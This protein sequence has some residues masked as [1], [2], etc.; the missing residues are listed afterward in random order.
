MVHSGCDTNV[1]A[2]SLAAHF[3]IT[4]TYSK[5]ADSFWWPNMKLDV[6]NF[7]KCCDICQRSNTRFDKTNN[8]LHSIP[9]PT[10]VWT[11][12]GVDLTALPESEDG[13]K[14]IAVAVDYFSKYIVAMPLKDKTAK[15]ISRFLYSLLCTHGRAKIQINDQ[16]REFVNEIS[17]NFHKLIG[18]MQ[19]VTSAYHPQAN[20][21]VER[22]NRT[23]QNAL[24]KCIK[25]DQLIWTDALPGIIFAYNTSLHE[26]SK[27]TPYQLMYG[28][29]A[30]QAYEIDEEEDIDP[31][32]VPEADLES[33][34][35]DTVSRMNDIHEIAA[36]NID[37]AQ[38]KQQRDYR[39]RNA[40]RNNHYLV[41]DQV[42]IWNSRRADRKGGKMTRPWMGPYTIV[43]ILKSNV[44]LMNA[45][46][47]ILKSK[48]NIC[49]IKHYF[50]RKD[51]K[52]C[53]V[54]SYN[55][56]LNA[57][58]NHLNDDADFKRIKILN[59][60][61]KMVELGSHRENIMPSNPNIS[62]V[63]DKVGLLIE[64]VETVISKKNDANLFL[65][66]NRIWKIYHSERFHFPIKKRYPK[67]DNGVMGDNFSTER[68]IGDGNCLFRCISK[69][70]CDDE[71]HYDF[72]RQ[73][74]ILF[75]RSKDIVEQME[76]FLGEPVDKYLERTRMAQNA[77]YGTEV[78]IV[79]L[80]TMLQTNII[81]HTIYK[82][83]YYTPIKKL[84]YIKKFNLNIYLRNYR[85]HFDRIINFN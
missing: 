33:C 59:D 37:L 24:L 66:T 15:S 67:N 78:E 74:C 32:N 36:G 82:W 77:T 22:V 31:D 83:A 58:E 17:N 46:G 47:S 19:R 11:Q 3:G 12:I 8:E 48:A 7:V 56:E 18:T 62:A 1:S 4:K 5:L 6:V 30:K 50:A 64:K 55:E 40:G 21:M 70:V 14:Y 75:M 65:P 45:S 85:E 84:S 13:Y 57:Q 42:L 10:K 72:L 23:I 20:G 79:A 26:S 41:N 34:F 43:R 52:N 49:N 38:L 39:S 51:D 69:E 81:I 2:I 35:Q 73:Q 61:T 80:A 68:I 54:V 76:G 28:R 60:E 44:E 9:I 71:C 29:K 53:E 63:I 27:F 16:G 25:D